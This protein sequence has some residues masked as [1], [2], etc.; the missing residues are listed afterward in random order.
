MNMT[1]SEQELELVLL[2]FVQLGIM[3]VVSQSSDLSPGFGFTRTHMERVVSRDKQ[4][5]AYLKKEHNVDTT[6]QHIENFKKALENSNIQK[7]LH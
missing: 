4:Y 7:K 2:E 5:I 6:E 1:R 3:E